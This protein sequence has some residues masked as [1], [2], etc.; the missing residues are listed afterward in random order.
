MHK[1]YMKKIWLIILAAAMQVFS[2]G[3]ETV[4]TFG[5]S[6]SY[7]VQVY[8]GSTG[9]IR[10]DFCNVSLVSI[11]SEGW[12]YLSKTDLFRGKGRGFPS[13]LCFCI[14]VVNTWDRPLQISRIEVLSGGDV[15]RP[16]T[17]SFTRGSDYLQNRYAV[18]LE[19]LWKTRRMLA[20]NVLLQEID[21]D[22]ETLEYKMDY[23]VPGDFIF[24]FRTFNWVNPDIPAKFRIGIKYHEMEKVIDFDLA[25]FEY[26]EPEPGEINMLPEVKLK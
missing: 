18:N 19:E 9:I 25:R 5:P 6:G 13:N 1:Q 20:D 22:N 3:P 16:E 23:I 21:F 24:F 12:K 7:D 10:T 17:F 11:D 8:R 15:V 14:M 4:R 2:C 26:Y